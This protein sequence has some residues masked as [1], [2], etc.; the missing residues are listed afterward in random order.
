MRLAGCVANW[1]YGYEEVWLR[2]GVAKRRC[3]YEEVWLGGVASRRCFRR[4]YGLEQVF[5]A[6]IR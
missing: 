3:G 5:Y 1:R 6:W 2:G 4:R